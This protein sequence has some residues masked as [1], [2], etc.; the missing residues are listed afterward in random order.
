MFDNG[1]AANI[2]NHQTSFIPYFCDETDEA[3]LVKEATELTSHL[4]HHGKMRQ[5]QKPLKQVNYF[6][7]LLERLCAK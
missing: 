2:G 7:R 1:A 5:I 4:G 6:T 3:N